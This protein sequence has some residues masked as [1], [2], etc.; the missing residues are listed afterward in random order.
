MLSSLPKLFDKSFVIGFFFPALIALIAVAW[1]FPNISLLDPVRTL[2]LSEKTFSD[3]TYLASIVWVTAILLMSLNITLYRMLEGYLPPLSWMRPLLWW[4]RRRFARLKAEYDTLLTSW[5]KATDNDR[6]FPDSEQRRISVL[7]TELLS[8]YP[9]NQSEFLPTCFGNVIRSF[10]VYPR[11]MYGVDSV[12]VWARLASVIPKDFAGFIDDARAQV[13]CFVNLAYL[14]VLIAVASLAC[15]VYETIYSELP[16]G[17][18]FEADSYRHLVVPVAA[19]AFGVVA[20]R[21]AIMRVTAWGDLV[22]SAFDCYLPALI[23]QLGFAVPPT[24]AERR[25]FWREFSACITYEQPMT[26]DKWRLAG[27]SGSAKVPESPDQKP[28]VESTGQRPAEAVDDGSSAGV[29]DS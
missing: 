4:H 12:P 10:E 11:E 6:P 26:A 21:W 7:R 23:K 13:D 19:V 1:I 2:A 27:E 9:R 15:T 25:D 16:T 17:S 3:L 18:I 22:K 5:N 8:R 29:R 20:Y 28:T 14:A 24:D